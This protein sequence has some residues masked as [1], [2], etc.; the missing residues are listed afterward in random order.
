MKDTSNCD[1]TAQ[2][3]GGSSATSNGLNISGSIRLTNMTAI[4]SSDSASNGNQTP[5]SSSPLHQHPA[6]IGGQH[7]DTSSATH[8][9]QLA[10]RTEPQT[11]TTTITTT[12][13]NMHHSPHQPTTETSTNPIHIMTPHNNSLQNMMHSVLSHSPLMNLTNLAPILNPMHNHHN[14][15]HNHTNLSHSIGV[16]GSNELHVITG[17]E[18]DVG[19]SMNNSPESPNCMQHTPMA[20]H[21]MT[22]AD[23]NRIVHGSEHNIH[24]SIHE[25]SA[26]LTMVPNLAVDNNTATGGRESNAVNVTHHTMQTESFKLE[27][28]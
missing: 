3:T 24:A 5:S 21:H 9:H 16:H 26:E 28:I 19:Q 23:L 20:R 4:T 14:H 27:Q 11:T 6:N 22:N 25:H 17:Q 18:T 1:Y 12:A 15:S 7:D 2:S 13:T 8:T 10:C